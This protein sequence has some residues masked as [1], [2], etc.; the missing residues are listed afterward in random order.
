MFSIN[1]ASGKFD[2]ATPNFSE[3]LV[4]KASGG[5]VGV[6]GDSRNS[7]ST[8]NSHLAAGLID[9]IFP[10][11]LGSYGSSTPILRMGDVLVAGKQYMNTQNG[12]DGQTN[13]T[14]RPR[15]TSTT[16]SAIRRC[17]SGCA[18][19]RSAS[20]ACSPHPSWRTPCCCRCPTASADGAVATL[21]ANGEAIGRALVKDGV[22]TIVPEGPTRFGA[23]PERR[24]DL[25]RPAA[26]GP[27]STRT[28][29]FRR[30]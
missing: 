9:A 17:R 20:R 5:A 12:L 18:G 15:S 6:I 30:R 24:C 29:T 25:P 4:E 22:A 26:D 14:T 11:T 21:Y 23:V 27:S 10:S 7:P 28:A 16:G 1:C 2:D 19:R 3:Q 8:T 13:A